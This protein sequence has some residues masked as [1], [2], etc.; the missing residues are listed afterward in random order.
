MM[1][2]S[3]A[4]AAMSKYTHDGMTCCIFID[5][6]KAGLWVYWSILSFLY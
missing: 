2:C 3:Y 5:M 6:E 4:W 1:T